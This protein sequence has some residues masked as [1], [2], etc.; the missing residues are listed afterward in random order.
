MGAIRTTITLASLWL[1]A[2]CG[3]PGDDVTVPQAQ[4]AGASFADI[5][6]FVVHFSAQ[7]TDQLSPEVARTYNIVRSPNRAMLTVSVLREDD[8]TPVE[9][10][11]TVKTVNLT[12]QMK[13]VTMRML[14]EQEAIYY[15]GETQ[16][17]NQETLSFEISVQP[18]GVDEPA[19]VLFQRQ[20]YSN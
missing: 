9:A 18:A 14:R 5:G 3:G 17:A 6:N 13:N 2:A 10:K 20:F 19:S 7:T 4:P 8:N 15:V 16:V 1:L 11:V 12:G